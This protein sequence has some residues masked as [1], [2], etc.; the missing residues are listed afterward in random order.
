MFESMD[1]SFDGHRERGAGAGN[2][3]SEPK[4]G[5]HFS[6]IPGEIREKSERAGSLTPQIEPCGK[7]NGQIGVGNVADRA[8]GHERNPGNL[9]CRA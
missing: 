5:R 7:W 3:A 4:E 9:A 6:R 8:N 2:S 1:A